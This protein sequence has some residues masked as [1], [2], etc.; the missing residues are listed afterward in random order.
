MYNKIKFEDEENNNDNINPYQ[1]DFDNQEQNN[2]LGQKT[3][4]IND[5]DE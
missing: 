1:S 5:Y 4:S 3:F 2:N